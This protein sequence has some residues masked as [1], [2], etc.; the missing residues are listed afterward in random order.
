MVPGQVVSVADGV[1][2]GRCG[3][4][5][6]APDKTNSVRVELDYLSAYD[7][8]RPKIWAWIPVYFLRARA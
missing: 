7:K 4:V 6:G 2:R 8:T 3:V 5:K 1:Y